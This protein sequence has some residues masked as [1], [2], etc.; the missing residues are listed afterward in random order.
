MADPF[1]GEIRLFP[2]SFVPQG[3]LLCAGQT[4]SIQQNQALAALLGITYGGDGRNTFCLPDLRDRAVI[5]PG[6]GPGLTERQYGMQYG[7]PSVTLTY[8]QMAPH[9][10]PLEAEVVKSSPSTVTGTPSADVSL[11]RLSV[12]ATYAETNFYAPQPDDATTLSPATITPSGMPRPSPHDNL[13]PYMVLQYC[14]AV[15]GDFPIS[16]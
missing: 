3:W 11:S 16:E 7:E 5:G 2:Y 1:I 9:T 6:F 15:E 12:G 4:L 8:A 13:Q 10:H 14:I